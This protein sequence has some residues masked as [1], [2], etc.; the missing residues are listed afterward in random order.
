VSSAPFVSRRLVLVAV[1]LVAFGAA[2]AGAD[3]CTRAKLKAIGKKE[4]GLLACQARVAASG[5]SSGLS[6]CESKVRTKFG[7]A[8]GNAGTCMGDQTA[9]ESIADGCESSI[10]GAF[11]DTFPSTCEARK[12]KAAAKLAK[13][14][15]GCYAKAAKKEIALDTS[16]IT[17]AQGKFGAA[18]VKAGACPDGGSPQ[19]EVEGNCVDPAVTTDGGGMVTDVCPTTPCG[20]FVTKWGS[21]G[22]GDGQFTNA[23]VVAVDGDDNVYVSDRGYGFPCGGFQPLAG[24]VIQKFTNDGTFLAKW[25]TTGSADGAFSAAIGIDVD[26]NG[27]VFVADG[28]EVFF[29]NVPNNNRVQ[30][31]TNDGTFL[32]KWGSAGSGDGEFNHPT[33][34]AVDGDGNVYVGD[35]ENH[36]VQKFTNDGTFLSKWGS[37]GSGDGEFNCPIGI[38]VDGNGNVFVADADN[39]RVQKFTTTGTFLTKWGSLGSGDGQFNIPADVAV[40]ARGN[41]Y[42]ADL[43]NNRIQKFTNTGIFLTKWG[44]L[45]SGDGQFNGET[46]V[47]VDRNDNVFVPDGT[48]IQKFACPR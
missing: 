13:G 36:R 33:G 44:S 17:K 39:H 27:N 43:Q 32:T 3:Q 31:F 30:K 21:C 28:A 9:C 37:A 20:T 35:C 16:C 18:L 23:V 24:A 15:L 10:A 11:I 2:P 26:R 48:R 5:D 6:A 7:H 47:V 40:D 1:A 29:E 12:R 45:G 42:V 34:V 46:S 14:E 8:F 38:H 22:T 4:S 41:V 25:G 19:S